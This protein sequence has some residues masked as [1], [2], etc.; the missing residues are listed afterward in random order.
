[1]L[2]SFDFNGA[3]GAEPGF[4]GLISDSAG[5]FTVRPSEGALTTPGSVFELMPT[6]GGGWTEKV[7]HN[8]GQGHG[9]AL[10]PTRGSI[11][12]AAGNLYGTTLNGGIHGYGTVFELTPSGGIWTERVLHSFNVNGSDGALPFSGLVFDRFGNLYGTTY[13]GGIH[14]RFDQGCGT[15][16]ELTPNGSGGWAEKVLHS[17][18]DNGT[19]GSSPYAGLTL[20]AAWQSLRHHSVWRHI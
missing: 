4:A 1:M 9:R 19:D 12:D 14:N 15:V 2:Y 7:L 20:D 8:F 16:F 5:N 6:G 11:F 13:Y 3:D 18:N 10:F 17:F